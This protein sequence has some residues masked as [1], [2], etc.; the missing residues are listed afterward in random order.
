M[1][2]RHRLKRIAKKIKT[3]FKLKDLDINEFGTNGQEG[4]NF[5]KLKLIYL[6]QIKKDKNDIEY[7]NQLDYVKFTM[8]KNHEIS[9]EFSPNHYYIPLVSA[10]I[11]IIAIMT[12]IMKDDQ[13]FRIVLIIILFFALLS[14]VAIQ[15]DKIKTKKGYF[16]KEFKYKCVNEALNEMKR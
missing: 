2:L 14:L 10:V 13:S 3:E 1:K 12:T 6:S 11:A 4:S 7:T 16:Y 9:K 8:E 5:I 15:A